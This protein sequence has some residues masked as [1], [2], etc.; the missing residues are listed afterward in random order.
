MEFYKLDLQMFAEEGMSTAAEPAA[1]GAETAAA[2]SAGDVPVI[3]AGDALP[4]G[5]PA[6]TQVAA[7]M[8]RQMARHPELRKVYGQNR[9]AGKGQPAQGAQAAPEGTPAGNTLE[10]RWA[11]AKKGEFAE[12]YGQDVA[13]AVQE[14]FKNQKDAAAELDKYEPMLKVLRD[15]AGVETNDELLHH[16]MDDDSLYEEAASEAGMTVPAY[17]QFMA[18]KKER[19]EQQRR[20]QA[21]QRRQ[22]MDNH[23]RKLVAQAEEMRKTFP[24]FDLQKELQNEHFL[25]MTSPEGG[26]SVE[27]AY[28]AIHHK[29]LGPQM[30]AYGMNRA[31][32]QMGQTIQ[33]Q[34]SRPTEG[35]MRAQG[36][37]AADIKIDPRKLTRG[38]RNRLY[39]LVHKNQ[40]ISFD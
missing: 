31:R 30:M 6:S 5:T 25:R 32:Q 35:A 19:D 13:R 36:Q 21:D 22:F 39:E 27:D 29:E 9:A 26:V 38:E 7:A 3:N 10:D 4:D 1:A 11:Q 28:Y 23:Y 16:I 33:A 37:P 20:E 12:L 2:E 40:K 14:R 8:N 15:R 24:D 17:K 34:R 18:L